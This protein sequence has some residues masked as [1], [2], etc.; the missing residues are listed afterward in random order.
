MLATQGLQRWKNLIRSYVYCPNM[1][2]DIEYIVISCKGTPIKYSP[3]PKTDR[4]WS[5]IYTYID[6]A[7]QPDGFYDLIVV[8]SFSKWPDL[9]KCTNPTTEVTINFLHELFA[10]FGIVDCLVSYN[11]TQLTSGDFL[12]FCE[13]FQIN[14]I[15]IAPYHPRS[16]GLAE[17]FVDTLKRA[18]KKASGT[19]TGKALQQFLHVYRTAPNDNTITPSQGSI[20]A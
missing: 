5:W 11:G 12:D 4:P 8:G 6:F 16:N 1:D 10:R 14:H 7:G 2:K 18:L 17:N 9:L 15:T 13:A 20:C 19:P 3:W